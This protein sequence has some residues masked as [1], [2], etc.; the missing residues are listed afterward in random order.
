MAGRRRLLLLLP[1]GLGG[2]PQGLGVP[3]ASSCCLAGQGGHS[4]FVDKERRTPE[5][6]GACESLTGQSAKQ[7]PH[8]SLGRCSTGQSLGINDKD[9]SQGG[10]ASFYL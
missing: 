8:L 4:Y 6:G 5:R 10:W 1:D 9:P 2:G 7:A 3:K